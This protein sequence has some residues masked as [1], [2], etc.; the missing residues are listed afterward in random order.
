[1][2]ANEPITVSRPIYLRTPLSPTL[3]ADVYPAHASYNDFVAIKEH[4]S[5]WILFV[6]K[7]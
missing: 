3:L 4:P 2:R 6:L 7:K 5:W 1:M